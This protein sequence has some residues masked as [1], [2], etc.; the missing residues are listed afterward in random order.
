MNKKSL[1]KFNLAIIIIATLYVT[2]I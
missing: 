1:V 2:Q